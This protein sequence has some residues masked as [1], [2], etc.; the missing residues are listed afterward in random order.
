[1]NEWTN[2]KKMNKQAELHIS[3]NDSIINISLS[4]HIAYSQLNHHWLADV[5]DDTNNDDVFFLFLTHHHEQ[6]HHYIVKRY[7]MGQNVSIENENWCSPSM[8]MV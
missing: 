2:E 7:P 3:E 4:V 5:D 8:M 1:M 6:H